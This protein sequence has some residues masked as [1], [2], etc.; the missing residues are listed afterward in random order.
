M[1]RDKPTPVNLGVCIRAEHAL[2]LFNMKVAQ[3]CNAL[4]L[5][6]RM[7]HDSQHLTLHHISDLT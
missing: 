2:P 7:T 1:F 4:S 6:N 5:C 3:V